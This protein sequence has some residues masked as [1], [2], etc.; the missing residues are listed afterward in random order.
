MDAH[1]QLGHGSGVEQALTRLRSRFWVVKGRRMVRN[2]IESCAQCRR[3]F[4]MKRSSQ[5]MAPLPRPRFQSIRVFEKIGVDYGGPY[6]TKQG[7]GRTRAKRYLCLFTCLATRAV[8]LE[9][10]YSLDTDSFINAFTR[11]TSRRGTPVYVISDNGTN[12]T[13]AERELR[14]LVQQLDLKKISQETTKYH[15]IDWQ[16][17][18]PSAPHFGGVF[19]AMVKS[20]KKA[21]K[22][23]LGDADITDEELHTAI[24]GAERLLNSRPI[25]YVSSDANDLTPLT[26]NHFIIGQLGGIFAPEVL[27]E[28]EVY[29]PRKRWHRIQELIQS[30][31]KRWK[32]EFLP[33]L[34]V[35]HKWFHPRHNLKP[36]DVVLIA[37]PTCSRGEWPLGRVVEVYPGSDGL[38]R[39]VKLRSKNKEYLRPIHRLC[40]LEYIDD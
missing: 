35:I 12:F 30:F 11:M 1:E 15:P 33:Q 9:M 39:T 19:E 34:N 22:A 14:E 18:P 32:K 5:K 20:A 25:T 28:A 3:R 21:I 36:G 13:C 40:P 17:N 38:V 23:I 26:P 16:F 24:C 7:R 4:S 27:E 31:W 8:H 6:L 10:A 29:N 37:E 2:V